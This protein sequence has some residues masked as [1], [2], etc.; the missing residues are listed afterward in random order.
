MNRSLGI[1]VRPLN[2]QLLCRSPL[3]WQRF[4]IPGDLNATF[5]QNASSFRR[6]SSNLW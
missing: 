1:N 3:D 2:C 6:A 5:K 4:Q